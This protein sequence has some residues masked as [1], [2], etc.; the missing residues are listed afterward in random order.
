MT[1]CHRRILTLAL[2]G[3]TATFPGAAGA[4]PPV[5]LL[6]WGSNG[7]GNGQFISPVGVATDASGNVYVVDVGSARVQKF[8]GTGTA[9]RSGHRRRRERLRR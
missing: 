4:Q 1:S 2:L 7:S 5:Y 8:T 9:L 6:Q 3:F